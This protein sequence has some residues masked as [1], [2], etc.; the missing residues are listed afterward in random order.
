MSAPG[1]IERLPRTD[2]E[3]VYL[4]D[5]LNQLSSALERVQDGLAGI[6]DALVHVLIADEG[7]QGE[8]NGQT[9]QPDNDR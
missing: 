1:E 6:T 5:S 7:D 2:S 9:G 3:L 4:V 8:R